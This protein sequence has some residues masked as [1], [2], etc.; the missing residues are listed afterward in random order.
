MIKKLHVFKSSS[1]RCKTT[2]T[3]S[4]FFFFLIRRRLF[5]ILVDFI[6]PQSSSHDSNVVVTQKLDFLDESIDKF[7]K[8]LNIEAN[9]SDS[10]FNL[11]QALTTKAELLEEGDQDKLDKAAELSKE[12]VQ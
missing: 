4:F 5:Y 7:R 1:S 6:S 8:A 10:W 9:N 11:A 3:C 12:A 2:H